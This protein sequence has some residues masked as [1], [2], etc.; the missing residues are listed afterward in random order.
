M[1]KTV[2]SIIL[3]DD[4]VMAVDAM[5]A[6]EGLSRSAKIDRLLAQ[7]MNVKTNEAVLHEVFGAARSAA[8]ESMVQVTLSPRGMLTMRSA[9]RYKYNPYILYT[10][11]P[12]AEADAAGTLSV[13]LR[14]S[15][16]TLTEGVNSFFE[17]WDA[18]EQKYLDAPPKSDVNAAQSRYRR[19]LRTPAENVPTRELGTALAEYVNLLDACIKTFFTE[20]ERPEKARSKT[21]EAYRARLEK[22]GLASRL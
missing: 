21:E 16:Q 19:A 4:V 12:S 20:V 8:G 17:L 11:E 10:L 6:R 1:G 15:S 5:A 3:S 13:S 22:A 7:S 14:S 18:L 9:L 2:Y